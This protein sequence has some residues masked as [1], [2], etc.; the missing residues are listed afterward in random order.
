ML[1]ALLVLALGAPS[2]LPDPDFLLGTWEGRINYPAWL[3]ESNDLSEAAFPEELPAFR[4]VIEIA[5]TGSRTKSFN[6]SQLQAIEA[7]PDNRFVLLSVGL[8]AIL[9]TAGNP[10]PIP[11]L[12]STNPHAHLSD[13]AR[14]KHAVERTV[15]KQI[16]Y[17]IQGDTRTMEHVS[18]S[19][20]IL[21]FL[22]IDDDNVIMFVFVPEYIDRELFS[23]YLT[24]TN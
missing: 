9:H 19:R 14:R 10:A 5:S 8:A 22:P 15:G 1:V 2:T 12:D 17:L 16:E 18:I 23:F 13:H 3:T 11:V 24:R 7:T 21:R 6:V 20:L 4:T